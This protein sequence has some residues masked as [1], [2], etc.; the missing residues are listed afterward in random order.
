MCQFM[1]LN[2]DFIK[3]KIFSCSKLF[4]YF[5]WKAFCCFRWMSK[6]ERKTRFP[7]GKLSL[8]CYCEFSMQ[9]DIFLHFTS[10]YCILLYFLYTHSLTPDAS[11]AVSIP[12]LLSVYD[13]DTFQVVR[14]W[15]L[16]KR[17]K[18]LFYDVASCFLYYNMW[19]N[20]VDE[21]LSRL[22]IYTWIGEYEEC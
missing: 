3:V 9:S 4:S 14:K 21:A 15:N 11:R 8:F 10:F 5:H 17:K 18:Q 13:T 6:K 22:F 20:A 7:R 16:E 1:V 2:N 12:W 19:S